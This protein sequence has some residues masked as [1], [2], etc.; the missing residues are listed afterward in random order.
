DRAAT[1]IATETDVRAIGGPSLSSTWPWNRGHGAEGGTRTPTPLRAQVPKTCAAAVTPLPRVPGCGLR[2][3]RSCGGEW[4]R[5]RV[6]S[7][8]GQGAVVVAFGLAEQHHREQRDQAQQAGQ[9]DQAVDAQ[10]PGERGGER[11]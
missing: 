6:A 2:S 8:G 7:G 10:A 11:G 3:L 9:D 4:V 1:G 5:V